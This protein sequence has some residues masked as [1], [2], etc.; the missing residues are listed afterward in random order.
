MTGGLD[1]LVSIWNLFSGILKYAIALPPPTSTGAQGCT[2]N[3]NDFFKDKNIA[4]E[5]DSSNEES[6]NG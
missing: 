2:T 6:N 3:E 4:E 5:S 1:G